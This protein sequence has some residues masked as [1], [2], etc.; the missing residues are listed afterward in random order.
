MKKVFSYILNMIKAEYKF[1]L[2]LLLLLI[3]FEWPVNY[4]IIIGGGTSDVS[5]RIKVENKF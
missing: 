1:I 2:V 3:I 5:S 4:Y